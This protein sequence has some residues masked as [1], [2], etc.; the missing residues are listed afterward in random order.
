MTTRA[1]IAAEARTWIGTPVVHQQHIKGVGC[2]CVGLVRGMIV[3]LGIMPADYSK[4]PGAAE[5]AGY[6]RVPDGHSIRRAC[7]MYLTPVE[8]GALQVGDVVLN[9]WRLEPPQHLAV[10]VDQR[11]GDWVMVHASTKHGQIIEERV[12]Y[13]RRMWRYVHG[14]S[15][16]GVQP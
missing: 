13:E 15:M 7:E 16:P 6:G 14:Y 9:G 12:T 10:I 4:W 3:E 5:F 8:R 2:D 11:Y 1:A